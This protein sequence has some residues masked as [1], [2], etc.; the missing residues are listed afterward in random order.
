MLVLGSDV[1]VMRQ[2]VEAAVRQSFA[3][4]AAAARVHAT[5]VAALDVDRGRVKG[6]APSV[7]A[8]FDALSAGVARDAGTE[9]TSVYLA[10]GTPIAWAGRPSDI[11]PDRI[12]GGGEDWFVL[13]QV[14]GLRMVHI[15]PVDRQLGAVVV[16]ERGIGAASPATA[17]AS[18]R[19]SGPNPYRMNTRWAT[20]ALEAP[21]GSARTSPDPSR[22]EIVGPHDRPMSDRDRGR[23][24]PGARAGT[25]GLRRSGGSSWLRW[26]WPRSSRQVPCSTGG[27]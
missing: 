23:R 1:M 9:A 8:L 19:G 4:E 21:S 18:L 17:L 12:G 6:D 16:T 7:R 3:R 2:R 24:G 22:F 20:V 10:D 15:R 25:M 26:P 14:L 11:P 27:R 5:T 13:E